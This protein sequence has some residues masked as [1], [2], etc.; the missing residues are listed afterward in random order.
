MYMDILLHFIV[1]ANK[2][3]NQEWAFNQRNSVSSIIIPQPQEFFYAFWAGYRKLTLFQ[4]IS[5][6]I[7][8]RP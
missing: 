4:I 7:A 6:D 3:I 2:M 5:S 1:T 8:V